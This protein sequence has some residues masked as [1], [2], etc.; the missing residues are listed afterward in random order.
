MGLALVQADLGAALHIDVK[1]P[2]DNEERSFDPS[3]FTQGNRQFV[4]SGVGYELANNR[5]G[6]MTPVAMVAALRSISGQFAAMRG[7]LI[8][9]PIS[10]FS[11]VGQAAGSKR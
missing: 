3:D 10:P 7:S 6:G 2:F 8:L 11:S 4:L 1:Q 5:L 9:P